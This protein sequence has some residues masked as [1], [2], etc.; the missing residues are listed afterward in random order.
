MAPNPV[1]G[2]VAAGYFFSH[3]DLPTSILSIFTHGVIEN[4][5]RLATQLRCFREYWVLLIHSSCSWQGYS[6]PQIA[7]H[8]NN[9]DVA[10]F[11]HVRNTLICSTSQIFE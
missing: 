1:A 6:L 7:V 11:E 10:K 5:S 3:Q 9:V 4:A 2:L 8:R